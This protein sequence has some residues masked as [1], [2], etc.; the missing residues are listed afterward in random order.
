MKKEAAM[1]VQRFFQLKRSRILNDPV[2]RRTYLLRE[3]RKHLNRF[4]FNRNVRSPQD[5]ADVRGVL[6]SYNDIEYKIERLRVRGQN[7]T[8]GVDNMVKGIEA[9]N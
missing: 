3:F 1:L 7:F 5:E 6:D 4:K 2:S 8:H 9:F